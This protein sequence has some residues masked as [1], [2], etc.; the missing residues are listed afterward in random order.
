MSHVINFSCGIS[1]LVCMVCISNQQREK[2]S[3]RHKSDSARS[4][5]PKKNVVPHSECYFKRGEP[6][7]VQAHQIPRGEK[8]AS[9]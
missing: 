2:Q 8:G 7:K 1:Y 3:G 4:S 5:G 9:A 6:L